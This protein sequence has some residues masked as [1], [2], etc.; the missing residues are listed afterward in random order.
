MT[1]RDIVGEGRVHNAVVSLAMTRRDDGF[2]LLET[3]D[4]TADTLIIFDVGY[5][6]ILLESFRLNSGRA[7]PNF[8]L[9]NLQPVTSN[10]NQGVRAYA[11]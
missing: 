10:P 4:D 5:I 2:V 3:T 6:T 9:N 11:C 7:V 1:R 8:K